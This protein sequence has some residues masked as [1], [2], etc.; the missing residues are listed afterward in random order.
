MPNFPHVRLGNADTKVLRDY[1][2]SN[3]QISLDLLYSRDKYLI[4]NN[5]D[6][7]DEEQNHVSERGIVFRFGI[8]LQN[9]FDG[10]HVFTEYNL[11]AEYNRNLDSIKILPG[12]E[13]GA[14]PD[15]IL[16]KRGSNDN[17]ILVC[18]F[19]TWW[20][21]DTLEDLEKINEFMDIHGAYKY[22]L[23]LSILLNKDNCVF[24]WVNLDGHNK[25][26]SYKPTSESA[27]V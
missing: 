2:Q 14:Y 1:L 13:K 24:T 17:N 3:I 5:P 8:Y 16:H 7:H 12:W 19:K 25:E 18:E 27:H 26:V 4:A 6:C 21:K 20:N 11:D 9:I 15:L 22:K 23:G 10:K